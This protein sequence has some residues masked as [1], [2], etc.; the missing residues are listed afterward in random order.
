MNRSAT[1]AALTLFASY[2]FISFGIILIR[3]WNVSFNQW[4][5]PL[6]GYAWPSDGSDP[7]CIPAGQLWPDGSG[8]IQ[9]GGTTSTSTAATRPPTSVN[10]AKGTPTNTIGGKGCPAGYTLYKGKCILIEGH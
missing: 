5:N 7:L 8:G 1:I 3:G 2:A 4:V 10:P 6:Q 9:C